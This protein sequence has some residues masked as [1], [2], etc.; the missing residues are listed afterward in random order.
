MGR[1][2]VVLAT[3]DTKGMEAF[4][5]KN[6]LLEY[7]LEPIIFDLGILDE[8]KAKPDVPREDILRELNIDPKEFAEGV[9]S[10]IIRRDEAIKTMGLGAGKVLNKMLRELGGVIGIGGNQGTAAASIAMKSLP[11]GIPKLLVST[12]ASGNIRPYIEYKDIMMMFSVSD[13]EFG[14][15]T[16]SKVIL[17]NAV[18]AMA[19]MVLGYRGIDVYDS[20]KRIAITTLGS[21][22]KLTKSCVEMLKKLNYEVVVFHASGAGGSAMEELIENGFFN[23]VLDLN[24]HELVGEVIPEDIYRPMKPRLTNAVKMGLPLIIAPGSINYL[25]FGPPESIPHRFLGRKT[26]YHN[27]YNTNVRLTQEELLSVADHLNTKLVNA[28]DNVVLILP[29]KGFSVLDREGGPLYEP[30]D[31]M[32]FIE[33]IEGKVSNAVKVMKINSNIN[34]LDVALNVIKY[35]NDLVRNSK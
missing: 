15:N 5:I 22:G 26:H 35:L 33:R 24:L 28:R 12:V 20:A 14:P 11:L 30:G 16:I 13:L 8:P 27:P 23:A 2:V 21:T 3:L 32:K 9:K 19:G 7:G 1:K 18:N 4:Y 31:D 6:L 34:D 25:V 10:G 29:L 17:R